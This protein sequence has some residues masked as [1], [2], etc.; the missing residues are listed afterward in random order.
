MEFKRHISE[1]W[2]R[3]MVILLVFGLFMMV[4]AQA[5]LLAPTITVSPSYT[6][7]SNGD[8]V[9]FTVVAHCT[10]GVLNSDSCKYNNGPLPTNAT[11]TAT[12]GILAIDSTITNTLTVRHVSSACA[13]TYSVT[14]SDL[15]GIITGNAS[16]QIT[17]GIL[18]TLTPVPA[19]TGMAS[20][21]FKLQF[22][23]P[24]GSNVVIQASS[25]LVHWVPISTNVITG[26]VVSYL[27]TAA[28]V[29]PSR[30]YRAKLR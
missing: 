19:Q 21:G 29:Y 28:K 23:G 18:P 5:Q 25:D 30:Y 12:A 24:T 16:T 20:T 3:K 4:R 7:V 22:A 6:N 27:D 8:T 10:L 26:G 17:L 2:V 14:F 1:R 11:F 15:L 13:G 9:T